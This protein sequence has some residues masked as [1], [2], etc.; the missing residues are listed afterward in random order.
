MSLKYKTPENGDYFKLRTDIHTPQ[1]HPGTLLLVLSQIDV[2]YKLDSS[3]AAL[4]VS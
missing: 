4:A 3:P 2:P 1:W